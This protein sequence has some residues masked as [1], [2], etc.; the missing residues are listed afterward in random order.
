MVCDYTECQYAVAMN[1]G[2]S[3][4]HALLMALDIGPGDDDNS[5]FNLYFSS[6]CRFVSGATPVFCGDPDTFN[7]T[8][9][10]IGKKFL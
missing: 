3:T 10:Q 2:T 4:L 7:V 9:E 6:K 8:A 5:Q 1:N